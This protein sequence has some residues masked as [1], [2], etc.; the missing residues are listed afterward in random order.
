[1]DHERKFV[2]LNGVKHLIVGIATVVIRTSRLFS[3][4]Q[5]DRFLT[6]DR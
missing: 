1:M 6:A 2:M 3:A 5:N 4:A